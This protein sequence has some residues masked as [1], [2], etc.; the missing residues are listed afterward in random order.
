[1]V[2]NEHVIQ[3]VRAMTKSSI[4]GDSLANNVLLQSPSD[5]VGVAE[6]EGLCQIEIRK[7]AKVSSF[8]WVAISCKSSW[9]SWGE[10]NELGALDLVDIVSADQSYLSSLCDEKHV[11]G[12]RKSDEAKQSPCAA[13]EFHTTR[14][15]V[16]VFDGVEKLAHLS[17]VVDDVVL[18]DAQKTRRRCSINLQS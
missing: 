2:P 17:P 16:T 3:V 1:M 15:L 14:A 7:N 10:W 6:V 12:L 4:N 8:F 9:G 13:F 5:I 18:E 11:V